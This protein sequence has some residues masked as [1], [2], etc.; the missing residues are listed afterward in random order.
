MVYYTSNKGKPVSLFL[1]DMFTL[2]NDQMAALDNIEA[3]GM[4]DIAKWVNKNYQY[5]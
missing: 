5:L 2:T 4:V 3:G 1:F